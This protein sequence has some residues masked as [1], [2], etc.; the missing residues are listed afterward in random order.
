MLEIAYGSCSLSHAL[1]LRSQTLS[2]LVACPACTLCAWICLCTA[3]YRSPLVVF[4]VRSVC[5]YLIQHPKKLLKNL[6]VHNGVCVS[7]FKHICV[8][9]VSFIM[10][11]CVSVKAL[12]SSSRIADKQTPGRSRQRS[13][14]EL[15]QSSST[16]FVF[17]EECI[18][19]SYSLSLR[20]MDAWALGQ[21]WQ[22]L[23]AVL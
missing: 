16:P 20:G 23:S 9:W 5:S 3:A 12:R 18:R 2:V 19:P 4:L 14:A 22:G 13:T 1:P 21:Q 17:M 7:V 8:F 15:L 10:C 6:T 11:E